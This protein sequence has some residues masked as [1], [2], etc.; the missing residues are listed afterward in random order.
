MKKVLLFT[1]GTVLMH[2]NCVGQSREECVRQVTSGD[3]SVKD[4]KKYVPIGRAVSKIFSWVAEGEE[5]IY[6]TS[7]REKRQIKNIREV[8]RKY[9]F[10]AGRLEYRIGDETY[11]DVVRRV[12]PDLIIEDDC[13]SI[14]G[15]TATVFN[16]IE[17]KLKRKIKLIT[18]KEFSGIDSLLNKL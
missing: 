5:I 10:P 11:G 17:R 9:N 18:V 15:K 6:L 1:E 2:A 12:K 14:G 4:Y 3:I 7:R 13:E 8:L 16:S